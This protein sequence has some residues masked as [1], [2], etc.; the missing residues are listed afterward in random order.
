MAR[1]Q[2]SQ[3][4]NQRDQGRRSFAV[5]PELRPLASESRLV[6]ALVSGTDLIESNC[7]GHW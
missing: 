4:L 3:S 5:A 2:R 6:G 1:L 7:S